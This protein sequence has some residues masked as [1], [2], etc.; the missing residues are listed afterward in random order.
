MKLTEVEKSRWLRSEVC[1]VV[2]VYWLRWRLCGTCSSCVSS[3]WQLVA[4]ACDSGN[5]VGLY[6]SLYYLITES[7]FLGWKLKVW[8]LMVVPSNDVA[9]GII[10]ETWTFSRV[11]T[12]DL[13]SGNDNPCAL[14]RVLLLRVFHHYDMVFV[15]IFSLS[16]CFLGCVYPWCLG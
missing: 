13:W 11:K 14:F 12:L 16:N 9:K 5:I 10:L 15:F 7:L 2:E 8:H 1:N 3:V 4:A 6:F